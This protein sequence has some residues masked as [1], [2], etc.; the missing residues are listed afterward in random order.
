VQ[1]VR[2]PPRPSLRSLAVA[3]APEA[4]AVAVEGQWHSIH[5]GSGLAGNTLAGTRVTESSAL[6][7]TAVYSAINR[8]ATDLAILSIGTYERLA[9]G[10]RREATDRPADR[11]LTVRP[12]G[13]VDAFRFRQSAYAKVLGRGNSYSEILIDRGGAPAELWEMDPTTCWPDRTPQSKRLYYE[14][15]NGRRTLPPYK[16]LH[17]AGLGWDGIKGYSPIQLARQAIGLGLAAE[18]LGASFFGNGLNNKGVIMYPGT[19]SPEMQDKW[20]NEIGR[21][22]QGPQNAARPLILTEGA[23]WVSTT[24]PPDDAQFLETRKFQVLEIARI[25]NLPPHKLGDYSQSHL[26]NLEESNLDYLQ[27]T[28]M[29][30]ICMIEAQINAKLHA[31]LDSGRYYSEHVVASFLRGNMQARAAFYKDLFGLA[32][33]TPNEIRRLENL[34][35]YGE[36]GNTPFV[37]GNNLVPLD[38]AVKGA[39]NLKAT[40]T[41]S[42]ESQS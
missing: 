9:D 12:N 13:E 28:L 2:I 19:L 32:A 25:F 34:E 17:L 11:L 35:S 24:I 23:K 36:V 38:Q 40:A 1:S 22:H 21:V 33:I 30:W 8:I 42:M 26:A 39:P 29:G 27:T 5:Y 6:T 16:V 31:G 3:T 7:F 10:S 20:R 18:T 41:R 15:D 37:A 4:R 14:V